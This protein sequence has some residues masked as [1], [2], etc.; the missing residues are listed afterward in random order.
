MLAFIVG[1]GSHYFPHFTPHR[2]Q[3]RYG[4]V[5]ILRG[6]IE[7]TEVIVLSRHGENHERLP[8]H[9]N[10]RANILALKQLGVTA[11]V[12]FS[13]AGVLRREIPLA[14][15]AII[16]DLYYPDNRLPSGEICSYF[17]T[18]GEGGRGHLIMESFFHK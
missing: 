2:E 3:T 5:E 17:D 6:T 14:I 12:G 4:E 11:I 18:I 7:G 9:I 10:F 8:N 13:V 15:P 16:T 1:T